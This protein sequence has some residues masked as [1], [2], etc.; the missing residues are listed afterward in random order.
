MNL[1][2]RHPEGKPTN[3]NLE[4][5]SFKSGYKHIIKGTDYDKIILLSVIY[6]DENNNLLLEKPLI[7]NNNYQT[8]VMIEILKLI[9]QIYQKNI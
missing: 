1:L 5:E 2:I 8:R 7:E 9:N 3:T 4:L 6:T